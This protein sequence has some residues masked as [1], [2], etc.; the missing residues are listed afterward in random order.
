MVKIVVT[1]DFCPAFKNSETIGFN[2][3]K[4][5]FGNFPDTIEGKDLHITNLECPLTSSTDRILKDGPSIKASVEMIEALKYARTDVACLAN[6]HILDFG[7]R[8][9]LDT[10]NL[11]DKNG[12]KTVGAGK[13]LADASQVL[14]LSV[15]N[16]TIA[17]VNITQHEFSIALKDRAGANPLNPVQNFYSIREARKNSS[18][19]LV[20]VH[21]G[22]EEYPLPSERVVDTYR[23]FADIGASAVISHH[24]HCISGFEVYNNVPIFYGL[25]NFIFE[26]A[27]EEV[28][29]NWYTGL[30]L[31]LSINS[32]DQI[33]FELKPF[34]QFKKGIGFKFLEGAEKNAIMEEINKYS[35]I[36]KDR[37]LLKQHW[38][39]FSERSRNYYYGGLNGFG[40]IRRKLFKFQI[41]QKWIFPLKK[42]IVL[43]DMIKCESHNDVIS[44]LLINDILGE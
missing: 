30:M 37:N 40:P 25:G 34:Y 31:L 12:I 39:D 26:L 22:N 41:M 10:I 44:E 38:N 1:G 8:G 5:I 20:I 35:E 9:L 15:K 11:C 43:Y 29:D 19:V 16:K 4:A 21:G 7:T 3:Y 33:A 24:A 28:P 13:N 32:E 14:Y 42:K 17:I 2:A 6:N 27:G 36:I 18:I 23:F